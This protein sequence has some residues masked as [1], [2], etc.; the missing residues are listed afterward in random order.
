MPDTLNMAQAYRAQGFVGPVTLWS[1]AEATALAGRIEGELMNSQGPARQWQQSRHLDTALG[2]ELCSHPNMIAA[3]RE[4]LGPHLVLWRSNF[5]NK[6]P[7]AC[8]IPWHQDAN[9]WPL[10]PAINITAWIAFDRVDRENACVQL[11]PGSQKLTVPHVRAPEDVDF[12]E[13]AD[14][15]YVD[16]STAVHMELEPGQCVI[17]TER[18]LHHSEVNR[19]NRRRMGLAVRVTVPIAQVDHDRLFPGHACMLLSGEDYM[20]LNRMTD[21]PA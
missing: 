11:I 12:G 9:Y 20:G 2:W 13:M 7:G 14:P 1:P 8:A 4:I 15:A 17:F 16:P 10:E 3:M 18:C 21:P 19:S 6:E 5:F